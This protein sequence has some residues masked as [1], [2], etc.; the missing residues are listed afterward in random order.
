METQPRRFKLVLEYDGSR[1]SGWQQQDDARTI[2]GSLLGAAAQLFGEEVDIQGNGRTDGGVHALRFVAHLEAR[3][4]DQPGS[5]CQRLNDLLPRDINIL[6]VQRAGDRFHARHNC[7]GRSYL[8][9]IARRRSAFC[10][11]YVWQITE[12]LRVRPMLEAAALFPGMHD[13][14]SFTDRQVVKKKSPLV[15]VNKVQIAETGDLFLI[16]LVAS[17]FLWKMVRRITGVLA[18]VGR[19]Q[20]APADVAGFLAEPVN[21]SKYTA[22]AQGLFFERAFYNQEEL[23]SF[24]ADD[25]IRPGFF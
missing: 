10:H 6:E 8:Y 18:A 3:T 1:Y 7:I 14:T 12:P 20:L 2:Q 23:A 15:M 11:R 5:L 17:H 24:L 25:T 4:R 19:E 21:L 22:P 13:F 9:Q 16:R